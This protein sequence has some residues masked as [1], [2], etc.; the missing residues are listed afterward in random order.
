VAG[1]GTGD[2]DAASL[3]RRLKNSLKLMSVTETL[4]AVGITVAEVGD[5]RNVS[6]VIETEW[7][8]RAVLTIRI[9]TADVSSETGTSIE[10]VQGQGQN[11]LVEVTLDQTI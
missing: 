3:L 7:Q 5:V 6:V 1:A 11:D 9:L 8:D 2:D 10:A 4:R